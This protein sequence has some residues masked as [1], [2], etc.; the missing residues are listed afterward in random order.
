MYYVKT[1]YGCGLKVSLVKPGGAA[2]DLRRVRYVGAVLHRPGGQT[3]TVSDL[4][5]DVLTNNVFVRLLP[6]RELTAEGDYSI[7]FNVKLADNTMYSTT[8][9]AIVNVDDNNEPGFNEATIALALTVVDFPSNVDVTGCSP[10]VGPNNTWLVYD[11]SLGAYVDTGVDVGYSEL[12]SR[13]DAK[14]AEF[15]TPAVEATQ[16]ANDAAALANAKAGAAND[17]ATLANT[18]AGL[19]NDAAALANEKAGLANQKAGLANDAAAAA[20]AAAEAA[21][22]VAANLPA[23]LAVL[24][25]S[26]ATVD[27]KVDTLAALVIGIISGKVLVEKLNVRNLGVWGS[28]NLVVVG[29]GAPSSKPDRAGQFYIDTANN[30]V[31]KSTGNSAVSDWK[32]I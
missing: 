19:A 30:A 29:S 24:S 21:G 18:K 6:S 2:V 15:V 10:K 14:F 1:G 16:A 8:L 27:K 9:T 13:Y 23:E 28:N 22:A 20:N 12:T 5:F 3:M 31:Y 32:T 7:V 4:N 11:D 17:A 26:D 25:H